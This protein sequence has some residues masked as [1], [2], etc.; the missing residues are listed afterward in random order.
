MGRRSSKPDPI[1]APTQAP[2][3]VVFDGGAIGLSLARRKSDDRA[4]VVSVVPNG[5]A[6]VAGVISGDAVTAVDDG[7]AGSYADVLRRLEGRRP[8]SL[9]FMRGG[10]LE[11]ILASMTAVKRAF[12]QTK[13][14]ENEQRR[15]QRRRDAIQKRIDEM[16][17]ATHDNQF[18][19]SLMPPGGCAWQRIQ[20]GAP[21]PLNHIRDALAKVSGPPPPFIDDMAGKDE[22]WYPTGIGNPRFRSLGYRT[23][24]S[25]PAYERLQVKQDIEKQVSDLKQQKR[26]QGLT[27][28]E[29][30]QLKS[31]QGDLAGVTYWANP[32]RKKNRLESL[33]RVHN[34][35]LRRRTI[36]AR[37]IERE[38]HIAEDIAATQRRT[39]ANLAL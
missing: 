35:T 36:S 28:K 9:G 4:V 15:D 3:R 21:P 6:H 31:L 19:V 20:A 18:N 32:T 38:L 7:D 27:D 17:P 8:V 24:K 14:A 2:Q 30:L 26:A 1:P 10:E 13:R 33:K 39:A 22:C 29:F 16:R 23:L 5:A 12:S 34:A 11:D 25:M 37:A